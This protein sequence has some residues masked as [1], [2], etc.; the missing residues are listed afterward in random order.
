[1]FISYTLCIAEE[2]PEVLSDF[3]W[4]LIQQSPTFAAVAWWGGEGKRV[5]QVVD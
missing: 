1:M 2:T 3:S 5:T 4:L